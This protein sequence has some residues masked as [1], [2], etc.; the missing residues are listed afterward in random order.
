M[1]IF[2]KSML[3]KSACALALAASAAMAG[4]SFGGIGVTIYATPD[5]VRVVD[6]VP[7]SPAAEAGL[8][9]DDR[10]VAVDGAS[11]AGRVVKRGFKNGILKN[12]RRFCGERSGN[13]W[14]FPFAG[15]R[16]PIRLHCVVRISP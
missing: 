8:E 11:L 9:K 6:V 7:G 3:A 14:K 15:K 2:A 13:R 10:I 4:E 12:P 5:G 1:K 16:N